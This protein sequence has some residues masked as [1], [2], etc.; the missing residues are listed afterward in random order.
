[1]GSALAPA[2]R[3]FIADAFRCPVVEDFGSA[4]LGSIGCE[5]RAADG[6]H[7]F[8]GLFFIEFVR[9]GRPVRP[10]ELGR[11]L[12]T[13]LTNRAMPLIRYDLGDIGYALPGNCSCGRNTPRFRVLGRLQD[14]LVTPSGGVLTEHQVSDFLYTYPGVDW[15]QLVQQSATH[16]D[17]QVVPDGRTPVSAERLA[18]GLT[19]LLG[20]RVRIAVRQVKAIAP[21]GGGK[22]RF[23]KS[24]SYAQFDAPLAP[25]PKAPALSEN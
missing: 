3:R 14:T 18:A 22:Y 13:D 12:V 15:F 1:M 4:E 8:P 20:G 9:N 7:L 23:V 17:L 6:L 11:M 19:N 25:S 10:G 21:E 5:C 2:A 24:K 16:F